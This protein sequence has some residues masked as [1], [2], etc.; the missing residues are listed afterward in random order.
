LLACTGLLD[1]RKC[2]THWIAADEFR[3][4]FPKV[5]LVPD[6]IITDEQA[7]IPAAAHILA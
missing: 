5:N 4:M 1:G 2:A 3:R 6:K 7:S